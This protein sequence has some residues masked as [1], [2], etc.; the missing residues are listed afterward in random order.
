MRTAIVALVCC[1]LLS[2]CGSSKKSEPTQNQ[3]SS[4]TT[5]TAAVALTGRAK[6]CSAVIGSFSRLSFNNE[7]TGKIEIKEIESQLGEL[8]HYATP[9]ERHSIARMSAVSR[10]LRRA[11]EQETTGEKRQADAALPGIAR[12]VK[13]LVPKVVS[14][15][16]AEAAR[17]TSLQGDVPAAAKAL[18][19]VC[20]PALAS[21]TQAVGVG[22][23]V[24]ALVEAFAHDSHR[25]QDLNYM[26][27]AEQ[28][29]EAG[30]GPKYASAVEA[31]VN[32]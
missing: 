10:R 30:C 26:Y 31:A 8:A 9:T 22:P 20:V 4:T 16:A 14:M 3:S 6:A 18:A 1:A 15:C 7:E 12:D 2:G 19:A 21:K 17:T 11:L 28:N 29:L 23:K 27:V 24:A 32:G 13:E 5:T 25:E